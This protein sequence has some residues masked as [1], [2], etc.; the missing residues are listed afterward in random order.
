MAG[1]VQ[2]F[3]TVDVEEWFHVCGVGGPLAPERWPLLPSRVEFTTDITLTLLARRGVTAHVLL[4]GFGCK[5]NNV[6]A[7]RTG[8]CERKK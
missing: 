3:L 5:G 6:S 2:N 4:D 1:Q 7:A 8:R